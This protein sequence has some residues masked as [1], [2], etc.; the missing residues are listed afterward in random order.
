MKA[1]N[2]VMIMV[3]VFCI[4][5]FSACGKEE[6]NEVGFLIR[7]EGVPKEVLSSNSVALEA[8]LSR[9]AEKNVLGP[10]IP[11]DY[12]EKDYMEYDI[13][14]AYFVPSKGYGYELVISIKSE[15]EEYERDVKVFVSKWEGD[16]YKLQ[17]VIQNEPTSYYGD[18][19]DEQGLYLVDVNFDGLDDIL[20]CNG[21]FGKYLLSEYNCYLFDGEE[22]RL[23]KS[24]DGIFEP[25]IDP[26]RKQVL[27]LGQPFS[28]LENLFEIY[29]FQDGEFRLEGR[30]DCWLNVDV[31]DAPYYT[32][33]DVTKFKTDGISEE[34][35]LS[36]LVISEEKF[37]DLDGEAFVNQK[38]E[39]EESY[40][41]L[42]RWDRLLP[43]QTK[44]GGRNS[45]YLFEGDQGRTFQEQ[46]ISYVAFS[47]AEDENH[48]E[49]LIDVK[50]GTLSYADYEGFLDGTKAKKLCLP[51]SEEQMKTVLAAIQSISTEQWEGEY[52]QDSNE[53]F[54]WRFGFEDEK[55]YVSSHKGYGIK[56]SE[57]ICPQGY[58]ELENLF[59]GL[60]DQLFAS[61]TGELTKEEYQSSDLV[62]LGEWPV[63]GTIAGRQFQTLKLYGCRGGTGNGW[64]ENSLI[65]FLDDYC[66]ET[67]C[68]WKNEDML[69][70][71]VAFT[72]MDEDGNT[73]IRIIPVQ[74]SGADTHVEGIFILKLQ[75]IQKVNRYDDQWRLSAD[76]VVYK[77]YEGPNSLVNYHYYDEEK[78][79]IRFVCSIGEVYEV[80]LPDW[81]REQ[82]FTGVSY[83]K[84]IYF[85]PETDIV[86]VRPVVEFEN[87]SYC[88]D[89]VLQFQWEFRWSSLKIVSVTRE[90]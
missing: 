31:E 29:V 56:R 60:V 47:L 24:F 32:E 18:L 14:S 7:Q 84:Q 1:K 26:E 33:Y 80:D 5:V 4:G 11:K 66:Y 78:N 39:A 61:C 77:A 57:D 2:I 69:P 86:E 38:L 53:N 20:V 88:C 43:R 17:Q 40:W 45:S 68:D 52:K 73:E 67:Y 51:L 59:A 10:N 46:E 75:D 70:P 83:D 16:E 19:V 30:L 37:S 21:A 74:K 9:S 81:A 36:R 89:I 34:D 3:F 55:G 6:R 54:R 72:D 85:D 50:E 48:Q 58:T 82:E 41:K 64:G 87:A 62:Y 71:Q 13:F 28:Y 76:A 22:Y 27:G 8:D 15:E 42:D 49:W 65:L 12:N 44:N 35:P 25:V 23:C 90:E 79:R 63:T